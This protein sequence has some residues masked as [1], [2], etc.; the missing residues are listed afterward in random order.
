MSGLNAINEP[1]QL[2]ELQLMYFAIESS[3]RIH[4]QFLSRHCGLNDGCWKIY[5]IRPEGRS[6]CK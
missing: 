2:E 5:A 1:N 3:L 4:P 6:S